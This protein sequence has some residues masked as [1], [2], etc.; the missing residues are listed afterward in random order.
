M[1]LIQTLFRS[2][3]LTRFPG[4]AVIRHAGSYIC[5]TVSSH[6]GRASEVTGHS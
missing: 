4:P 1:R 6:S 2:L 3:H 5:V